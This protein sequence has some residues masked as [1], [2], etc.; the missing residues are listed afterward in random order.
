MR[1]DKYIIKVNNL[2]KRFKIKNKRF[3]EALSGITLNIEKGEIFGLLGAN[4]AGKTTLIKILSTLV[5]PDSGK[6][7]I[8]GLDVIKDAK[9]I[10]KK[11]GV[12]FGSKMIYYRITGRDN[13]NFFGKVYNVK[14]L[15]ERI[16]EM[17]KYFDVNK[18][19]DDLVETYST[20]MKAKIAIIRS[21]IHNPRVVFLDEPT[22]GL[23]PLNSFKLRKRIEEIRK[24]WG[25]TIIFCSH[26]LNEVEAMCDRVGIIKKGKLVAVDSPKSLRKKIDRQRK[27]IIS[28]KNPHSSSLPSKI[29]QSGHS[30]TAGQVEINVFKDENLNYIFQS[31]V[32]QRLIITDVRI[33]K[34]TFE[35]AFLK[36]TS[37]EKKESL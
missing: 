5:M 2:E 20:G 12:C 26:Y 35:E 24:N 6:A 21:I 33:F 15:K 11:I 4:G 23:D 16:E 36:I 1:Q 19:L 3:S 37:D 32:N 7:E 28:F 10:R 8:D 14:N 13:L 29:L 22:L 31:F 18:Q 9:K 25:S 34:P 27:L 30:L 17:A